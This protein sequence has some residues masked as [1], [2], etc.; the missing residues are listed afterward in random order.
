MHSEKQR[1]KVALAMA[2]DF[3]E[4]HRACSYKEMTDIEREN[5]EGVASL[6]KQLIDEPEDYHKEDD[7]SGLGC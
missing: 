2:K 1:L 6:A 4:I 7:Q 5:M 3:L